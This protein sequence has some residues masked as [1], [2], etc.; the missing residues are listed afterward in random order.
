MVSKKFTRFVNQVT[1]EKKSWQFERRPTIKWG[2]TTK[3]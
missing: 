3:Y 2:S 1:R